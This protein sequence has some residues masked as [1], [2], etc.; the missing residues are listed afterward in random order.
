MVTPQYAERKRMFDRVQ[1]I[2]V[3]NQPLVPLV[4][5]N[6]LAGA[7]KNLANFRPAAARTLHTVE[8]RSAILAGAAPERGGEHSRQPEW[9]NT[10]LVAECLAGDDAPGARCWIATRT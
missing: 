9:S 4:S 5:P 2:I 1:A 8:Y 10:R 7:K 3:E 6:L